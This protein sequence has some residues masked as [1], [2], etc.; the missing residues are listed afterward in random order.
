MPQKPE[1]HKVSCRK[2]YANNKAYY[3][4]RAKEWRARMREFVHSLKTVCVDCGFDNPIALDFHHISKDKEINI[5]KVINRGWGKTRILNEVA[6]CILL[7]ANCHRIRHRI[8]LSKPS[9]GGQ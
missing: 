1:D 2:H 7:C 9:T 4:Q 6:K 3:F 5:S 8:L